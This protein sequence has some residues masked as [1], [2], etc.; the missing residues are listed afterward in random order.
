MTDLSNQQLYKFIKKAA[1]ATYAGGG[2]KEEKVERQ[3]FIELIFQEEDFFYRDS[4]TGFYRSRGME[5]VRHKGQPV[6]TSAYGGGM[7]EG[8]EFQAQDTFDF[9]KKAMSAEEKGFL[10]FRG[11]HQYLDG[12][13]KYVYSQEGDVEEFKGHE[14]IYFKD[15][16]VF[17]HEI[18]GGLVKDKS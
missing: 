16:L 6:W 12:D 11:P 9:L 18:I 10:S 8:K 14:E 5:V 4:Y 13:W 7:V 1:W 2:K 17:F 15:E 3:G